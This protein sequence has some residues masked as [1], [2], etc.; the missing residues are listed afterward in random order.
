MV[1]KLVFF[2]PFNH[3]FFTSNHQKIN[4]ITIW[5]LQLPL[6]KIKSYLYSFLYIHTLL[7]STSSYL[8]VGIAFPPA[9]AVSFCFFLYPSSL[10]VTC[11]Q[12]L[13]TFVIFLFSTFLLDLVDLSTLLLLCF[14]TKY[15]LHS[16]LCFIEIIILNIPIIM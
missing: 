14:I 10:L 3:R 1:A 15:S 5:R 9:D 16:S 4:L 6:I 12:L 7:S 2:F 13:L 11:L 8:C